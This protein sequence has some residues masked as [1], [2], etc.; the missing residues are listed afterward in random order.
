M[1]KKEIQ[2]LIER[3]IHTHKIS[4]PKKKGGMWLTYVK[5]DTKKTGLKQIQART[6]TGFYQLLMILFT[7]TF[8]GK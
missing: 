2:K 1:H 4:E 3:G 8:S 5:D 6:E 7:C